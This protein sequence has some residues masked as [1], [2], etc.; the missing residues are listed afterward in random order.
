MIL[1]TLIWCC[2]ALA[3]IPL[4]MSLMNLLCYR[5]LPAAPRAGAP[6]AVS[7]LIP[8]RNEAA[9]IEKAIRAA[10]ASDG[11]SVE[12]IVLDDH[13]TDQ[14]AAIVDRFA[15][16]DERVRLVRSGPLPV[17]WNGK[18][19]A[20]QQLAQLAR[21]DKL[22]WIDADVQLQPDALRRL[23]HQL[24]TGRAALISG[25]PKQETVTLFERLV[26]SCIEL[27]LLGYLP[28]AA[29]R[30]LN[31]PSLATGCG[32]LFA[33]RRADYFNAGGHALIKHSRHDG[34]TLP[35]AFRR[36]GYATDLFDATDVA[37][38]RMYD[39]AAAVWNGFAK[40]ADEGLGS[41][42]GIGVWTLL[43][44]GG[45]IGPWAF[46]IAVA[47]GLL[48][49][50][51]HE[52]Y[53]LMVAAGSGTLASALVA[54]RC[55]QSWSAALLRPVGIALVLAIQWHALGRRMSGQPATWR[56]RAYAR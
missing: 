13:S 5:R 30:W 15:R 42:R 37:R 50:H 31:A 14:T 1:T 29:M 33:A 3:T 23:A 24:D 44:G 17:G 43:L 52:A 35:P 56:G 48:P 28:M 47:C 55:R 38:C 8:A 45:F 51:V 7:L 22:V 12:L 9:Q 53:A 49:V 20:C 40:N 26:V 54:A 41:A 6:V 36:A 2:A 16:Q 25:F 46:I 18:Q 10:L 11:V 39:S 4:V 32:Q 34:V 21:H 19:Y 27:L